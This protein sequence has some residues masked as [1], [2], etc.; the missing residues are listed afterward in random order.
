MR[1]KKEV[2]ALTKRMQ[3]LL[4]ECPQNC[5]QWKGKR[6]SKDAMLCPL[7]YVRIT[8]YH[9]LRWVLGANE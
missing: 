2:F 6:N 5:Y 1:T 3:K 4:E 7:C 9:L 8:K